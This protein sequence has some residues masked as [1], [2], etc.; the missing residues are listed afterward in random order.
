MIGLEESLTH[1]D[2]ARLSRS[3]GTEKG[4]DL[5]AAYIEV[6]AIHRE[7]LAV[8]LGQPAYAQREIVVRRDHVADGSESVS[9][10]REP[11]SRIRLRR[12]NPGHHRHAMRMTSSVITVATQAPIVTAGGG[13]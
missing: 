2:R 8:A 4:H 5:A 11:V 1:F 3:V 9:A 13:P 6:D 12:R 10:G 7:L